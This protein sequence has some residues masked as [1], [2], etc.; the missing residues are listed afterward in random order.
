ML[1]LLWISAI[2]LAALFIFEASIAYR[3]GQRR[4]E[5]DQHNSQVKPV[6]SCRI[7]YSS[8]DS[9]N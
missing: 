8:R 9:L 3:R 5:I 1:E 4:R 6:D 7:T 2:A